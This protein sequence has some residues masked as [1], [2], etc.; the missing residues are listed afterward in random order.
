MEQPNINHYHYDPVNAEYNSYGYKQPLLTYRYFPAPGSPKA[1]NKY[2]YP[3]TV[4]DSSYPH[5][6]RVGFY[7]NASLFEAAQPFEFMVFMN[8]ALWFTVYSGSNNGYNDLL[9]IQEAIFLPDRP[10]MTICLQPVVGEA[11]ISSLELRQLDY[12]MYSYVGESL[13]Y[14]SRILRFS[15]GPS[16]A[17]FSIR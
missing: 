10:T 7:M 1:R 11:F 13:Q 17:P 2:C 14:L 4:Q 5:L 16:D 6:F 9:E 12:N 8:A 3:L 15:L